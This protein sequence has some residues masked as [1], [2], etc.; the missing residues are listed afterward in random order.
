MKNLKFDQ[1]TEIILESITEGVFTV[2][3]EG[4][5]QSFNKA[6]EEITGISKKEAIGQQCKHI[7]KCNLCETNC[8]LKQTLKTQKVIKNCPAFIINNDGERIPISISTGILKDKDG[9]ILGGVE[10]FRDLSTEE[11]LRK[12]IQKK[13]QF[14]DLL[15]N[16]FTMKKIFEIL[17][18]ISQSD[19]PVLIEGESGTGKEVIA[20]AI[21]SLSK[22]KDMPFVPINCSAIPETLLESELFGYKAGAFS[23]ANKDKIGKFQTADKGVLF[24][25]EIGEVP[26]H[27]QVKLLRAL[28]DKKIELLGSNKPVF[29]DVRI[30]SATNKSL[31]EEV[32]K[33]NFRLDFFFRIN[34]V[35]IELPPLRQRKDDIPNLIKQ[36]INQFNKICNKNIKNI[37]PEV[38]AI[39]YNYGYPGNIRELE[40]IIEYCFVL[41]DSEIICFKHLPE[42][43]Q[44]DSLPP[45]KHIE[46]DYL[47]SHNNKNLA[48]TEEE[49]ILKTLQKNNYHKQNTAKE[50][51]INPSTLYRKLKKFENK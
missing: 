2:N 18:L 28:Q 29:C 9:F 5:I 38:L 47:T 37:S 51:G 44:N 30:I 48:E 16:S 36:F 12:Q 31:K 11:L 15:S 17:P 8:P 49:I 39:L 25:D 21:H 3:Q 41:C 43:L 35:K 34:V 1:M 19:S 22:R 24:L 42:Y 10:T 40:N 14:G 33:G 7:F 20:R 45:N 13:W 32:D 46:Q 23:G 4:L 50:L 6:A 27:I 26:M